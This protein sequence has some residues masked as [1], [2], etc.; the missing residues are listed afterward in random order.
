[1]GTRS[2]SFF[3]C[4]RTR[5]SNKEVKGIRHLDVSFLTMTMI[6]SALMNPLVAQT[7]KDRA[8]IQKGERQ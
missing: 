4:C 5:S 8:I 2:S 1:M 6:R 3:C 7:E